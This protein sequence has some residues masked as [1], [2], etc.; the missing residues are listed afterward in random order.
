MSRAT[1][2]RKLEPFDAFAPCPT[3]EMIGPWWI[4]SSFGLDGLNGRPAD[5][6][7]R[8]VAFVSLPRHAVSAV[9]TRSWKRF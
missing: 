9:E 5:G 6:V 8:S 1:N 3:S 2:P 7:E 4:G